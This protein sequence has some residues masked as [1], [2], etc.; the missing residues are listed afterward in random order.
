MSVKT[1][2]VFG[3]LEVQLFQL[4]KQDNDASIPHTCLLAS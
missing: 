4:R 3:L 1:A 2:A